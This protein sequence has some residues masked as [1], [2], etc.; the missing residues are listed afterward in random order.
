MTIKATSHVDPSHFDSRTITIT[1]PKPPLLDV[2]GHWDGTLSIQGRSEPLLADVTAT[3]GGYTVRTGVTTGAPCFGPGISLAEG[4]A[5]VSGD[6]VYM[7]TFAP[8]GAE[9]EHFGTL[10]AN[11]DA[12]R[13]NSVTYGACAGNDGQESF[14][15]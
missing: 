5:V 6:Q 13:T 9:L 10:T 3:D 7:D 2:A 14:H 12:L 15:R 8:S 11:P 4:P 1:A